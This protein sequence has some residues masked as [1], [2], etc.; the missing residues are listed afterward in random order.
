MP[1]CVASLENSPF[2]PNS[3]RDGWGFL[4]LY[5]LVLV[6]PLLQI[7]FLQPQ[8]KE[9]ALTAACQILQVFVSNMFALIG[10]LPVDDNPR[11]QRRISCQRLQ[12][13]LCIRQICRRVIHEGMLDF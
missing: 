11:A 6:H 13:E 12:A 2:S 5:V 4:Q 10:K 1:G 8:P 7:I 3:V 9:L